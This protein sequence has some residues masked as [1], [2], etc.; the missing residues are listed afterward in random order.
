MYGAWRGHP[1]HLFAQLAAHMPSSQT[2][3]GALHSKGAQ[4]VA[5]VLSGHLIEH[6]EGKKERRGKRKGKGLS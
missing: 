2:L 4:V 1:F 6:N 3:A 5:Q